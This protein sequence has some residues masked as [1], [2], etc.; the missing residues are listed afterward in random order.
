MAQTSK[1]FSNFASEVFRK[2]FTNKTIIINYYSPFNLRKYLEIGVERIQKVW[3]RFDQSENEFTSDD[4]CIE[5]LTLDAILNTLRNF[6]KYIRKLKIIIDN[7][8]SKESKIISNFVNKY[9]SDTITEFELRIDKGN[10]QNYLKNSFKNAQIVSFLNRLPLNIGGGLSMNETFPRLRILS[11]SRNSGNVGYLKSYLPN[12]EH[13]QIDIGRFSNDQFIKKIF[14]FNPDIRSISLSEA[15]PVLLR[16]VNIMLPHLEH[17]SVGSFEMHNGDEQIQFENVKTFGVKGVFG[18]SMNILLPNLERLTISLIESSAGESITGG[19][20]E[21][22]G[23]WAEFMDNH[24]HLRRFHLEYLLKNEQSKYFEL[25]TWDLLDLE[26]MTVSSLSG[27][28]I[29][30]S[31]IIRFIERHEHLVRFELEDCMEDD[32]HTLRERFQSTWNI[33]NYCNGLLFER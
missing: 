29:H 10:A 17:L 12:L 19:F 2:K 14:R 3:S 23:D 11:L 5:I 1:F 31:S 8:D 22:I 16:K 18:S 20:G 13:V 25:L 28:Y 30:I 33:S 7:A 21:W 6:G 32:K 27:Q 4:G 24:N 15:W 9:C 26:E